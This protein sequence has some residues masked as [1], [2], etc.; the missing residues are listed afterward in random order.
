MSSKY[1]SMLVSLVERDVPVDSLRVIVVVYAGGIPYT[2]FGLDSNEPVAICAQRLLTVAL[3]YGILLDLV[4]LRFIDFNQK[5]LKME[6]GIATVLT[7][8]LRQRDAGHSRVDGIMF[9]CKRT[10][11]VALCIE[12]YFLMHASEYAGGALS[13]VQLFGFGTDL[14]QG[15][16]PMEMEFETSLLVHSQV[17]HTHSTPVK[18]EHGQRGV[19]RQ[20]VWRMRQAAVF[21]TFNSVFDLSIGA[22]RDVLDRFLARLNNISCSDMPDCSFSAETMTNNTLLGMDMGV[23]ATGTT[24]SVSYSN[25]STDIVSSTVFVLLSTAATTVTTTSDSNGVVMRQPVHESL[26]YVVDRYLDH[27][28]YD[29][30]LTNT[31]RN[32]SLGRVNMHRAAIEATATTTLQI[33]SSTSISTVNLADMVRRYSGLF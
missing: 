30:V 18:V 11:P 9:A 27:N 31:S 21:T 14:T 24:P 29:V 28:W 10:L 23:G 7:G 13:P 16:V 26:W 17:T 25:S 5:I 32:C 4:P 19:L 1:K 3:K 33:T 20:Q 6:V 12:T 15:F 22:G 8:R 2:H